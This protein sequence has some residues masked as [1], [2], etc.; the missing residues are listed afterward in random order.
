LKRITN[1]CLLFAALLF[2][3]CEQNDIIS[4]DDNYEEWPV[5]QDVYVGSNNLW[6]IS[7][8]VK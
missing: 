7:I 4:P 2:T 6:A 3:G 8:Y 1:T 5:G